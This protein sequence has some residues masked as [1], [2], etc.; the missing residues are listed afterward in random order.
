LWGKDGQGQLLGLLRAEASLPRQLVF[1]MAKIH[2]LDTAGI[3]EL[4]R[5]IVECAKREIQMKLVMPHGV[6][7]EALRRLHIFDAWQEFPEEAA[8]VAAAAAS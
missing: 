8:A 4:V 1:N 3:C 6:P 2:H 5:V 7:G